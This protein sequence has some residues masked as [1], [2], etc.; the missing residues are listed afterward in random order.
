MKF[1][2]ITKYKDYSIFFWL[3]LVAILGI[4]IATIYNDSQNE[5]T[6]YVNNA[7]NNIYLKKTV[8]EITNNLIPRYK[9]VNYVSRSGDKYENIIYSLSIVKK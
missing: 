1:F 7:L 6:K 8:Q 9:I 2:K 3:I 5:K 4:I